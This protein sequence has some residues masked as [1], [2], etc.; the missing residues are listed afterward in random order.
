MTRQKERYQKIRQVTLI[1]ALTNVV[2][3]CGKVGGG[4]LFHSHALIADGLH[5]FADLL[6][7]L[8]VVFASRYGSQEADDNHPYGHGRIETA[9]TVLLALVLILVGV[10]I[11]WDALDDILRH[12]RDFPMWMAIPVAVASILVKEVL[13]HYTRYVG[14]AI[15]SELVITNAWHHRSDALSSAVVLIGL[16]GALYGFAYFDTLAAII[17]GAMIIKMGWT[18]GWNSIK[19]L[20]DTAVDEATLSKIEQMITAVDGVKKVHQLRSRMMAGEI[21][22]DVHILV[23]PKLSVSE[24][25]YIAQNVHHSLVR[26][27]DKVRDVT[28]H[29]D[30]EDDETSCPSRHLPNRSRLEQDILHALQQEF[31]ILSQWIIHYLDGKIL[32]DLI[33]TGKLVAESL[34]YQRI[35]EALAMYPVIVQIRILQHIDTFLQHEH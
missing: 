22:I 32:I 3:G 33:L 5:S 13:F 34:F 21:L 25:H 4:W 8:M 20:V 24:G 15:A 12:E 26:K 16:F 14:R 35:E 30:P 28:V 27:L 7:D 11:A 29:V 1:G 23:R 6:T 2:L 19:E 18:Y 9:A 10:G 31:P 17:V